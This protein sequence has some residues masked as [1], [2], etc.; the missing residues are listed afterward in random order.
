MVAEHQPLTL[1]VEAV[2]TWPSARPRPRAWGVAAPPGRADTR[3]VTPHAPRARPGRI[4]LALLPLLLVGAPVAALAQEEL[5]GG[6]FRTGEEV[7]IPA[8]ETI[9]GDLYASAG[10]VRIDG[11][12]DGDLVAA[13]G[14]VDVNGEV[15]GDVLAG[16]GSVD[17]SGRVEGD[18]RAGAG[19]VTVEGSIGEDLLAGAGQVSIASGGVVGEDLVFGAGR[20]VL[21]GRVEGDV[22]GRTGRYARRGTVGGIEDVTIARRGEEAPPSAGDRVVGALRRFVGLVVV[23]ALLLWLLPWSVEGAAGEVRRRPLASLGAGALGV[24]GA[25]VAVLAIVVVAVLVGILLGMVSLGNLVGLTVFTAIVATALLVLS[26][27]LALGYAG[28]LAVGM[29]LAG[30]AVAPDASARR[31]GALV[32]GALLVAVFTSLPAVGGWVA[33]VAAVLGLGA[34]LLAGRTRR[35]GVAAAVG[36]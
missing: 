34:I 13:G 36:G 1:M 27:L 33:L 21:D 22:L 35:R 30:L 3:S 5:L 6:K 24:V 2:G 19:Q 12:V 29:A 15:R 26:L 28:Q 16:A 23:G 14:D 18:V 9:Q 20:V 4:L 17:V 11:V 32:L 8:G 7:S 25:V 10:T 31:W